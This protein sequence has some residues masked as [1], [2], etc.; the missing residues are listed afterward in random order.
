MNTDEMT[1]NVGKTPRVTYTDAAALGARIEA[2]IREGLLVLYL[3]RTYPLPAAV[4]RRVTH[5]TYI[6]LRGEITLHYSDNNHV[7]FFGCRNAG[8]SVAEFEREW[9]NLVKVYRQEVW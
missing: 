8:W 5:L 4:Q 3:E 6:P 2:K 9:A 1:G 7:Q